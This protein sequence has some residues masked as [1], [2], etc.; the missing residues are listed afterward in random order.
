MRESTVM[1]RT[2]A[3]AL[4]LALA[5]PA[6]AA[7]APVARGSVEQVHISGAHPGPG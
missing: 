4:L 3:L 1:P 5:L 6:T 7:A 2:L